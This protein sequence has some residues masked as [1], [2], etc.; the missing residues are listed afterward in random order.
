MLFELD[1]DKTNSCS[2]GGAINFFPVFIFRSAEK[3]MI[4][5]LFFSF[6][7]FYFKKK[8]MNKIQKSAT[9]KNKKKN[10]IIHF[11]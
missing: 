11:G 10:C 6:S 7:F 3:F 1:K 8:K 4:S 9:K 2:V 5:F